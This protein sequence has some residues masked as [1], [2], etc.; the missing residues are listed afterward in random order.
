MLIAEAASQKSQSVKCQ[1]CDNGEIVGVFPKHIEREAGPHGILLD[2][3]RCGGTGM[4]PEAMLAWIEI[5]HQCRLIRE[6]ED[7]GLRS[8]AVEYGMKPSELSRIETGK[9]DPT[10]HARRLGVLDEAD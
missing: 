5:G 1:D 6:A 7:L 2:C 3:D 4:I 8:G 10:E 9:D